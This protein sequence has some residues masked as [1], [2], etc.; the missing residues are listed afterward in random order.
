MDRSVRL[1][2]RPRMFEVHTV[3]EE[4]GEGEDRMRDVSRVFE[5]VWGI[6]EELGERAG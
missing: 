6:A 3:K 4:G 5:R 2:Q 1:E